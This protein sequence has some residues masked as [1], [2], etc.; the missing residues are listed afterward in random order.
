[1][2][3]GVEW[4]KGAWSGSDG[5]VCGIALGDAT[6]IGSS[7]GSVELERGTGMSKGALS[8]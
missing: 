2:V 4:T 1:M 6:G 8:R 5:V 3:V 7:K